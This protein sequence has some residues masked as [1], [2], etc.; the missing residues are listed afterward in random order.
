MMIRELITIVAER[1][2]GSGAS[3]LYDTPDQAASMSGVSPVPCYN[4]RVVV[5]EFARAAK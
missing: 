2:G 1:A 4:E 3:T 5:P